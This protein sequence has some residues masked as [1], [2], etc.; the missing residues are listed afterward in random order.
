MEESQNV[1][2]EISNKSKDKTVK[3]AAETAINYTNAFNNGVIGK[4]E[5]IKLMSF[6]VD[7]NHINRNI[8][9]IKAMDDMNKSI[10]NLMDVA[11]HK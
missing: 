4:G 1:L 9:N 10:L 11:Q 5:Y 3:G 8:K 2:T 7:T 6:I